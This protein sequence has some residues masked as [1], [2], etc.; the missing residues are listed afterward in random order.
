MLQKHTIPQ[1]YL[2]VRGSHPR[3][4][5]ASKDNVHDFDA[6]VSSN[7]RLIHTCNIIKYKV[8]YLVFYEYCFYTLKI[9]MGI[10]AID[11]NPDIFILAYDYWS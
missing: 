2:C 4:P 10:S 1:H 8:L 6:T 5:L 3:S 11:H 7:L 9:T